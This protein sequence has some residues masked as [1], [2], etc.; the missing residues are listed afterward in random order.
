MVLVPDA[1]VAWWPRPGKM[2]APNLRNCQQAIEATAK[3]IVHHIQKGDLT[4][5]HPLW[6]LVNRY[7]VFYQG[8]KVCCVEATLGLGDAPI[9]I[10]HVFA[11]TVCE[12]DGGNGRPPLG[13]GSK[14]LRAHMTPLFGC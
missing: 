11:A 8:A 14:G 4:L 12:R 9:L 13:R 3:F 6:L 7:K 2:S 1:R 10:A 5:L